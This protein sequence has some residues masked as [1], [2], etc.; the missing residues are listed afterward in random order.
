M[1][2]KLNLLLVLF[3]FFIMEFP[4][5]IL[6]KASFS[7]FELN[8]KKSNPYVPELSWPMYCHDPYHTGRSPYSTANN[9]PD[10]IK[11][12][13]NTGKVSFYGDVAVGA[14]GTI[15]AA[16]N[17]LF[18]VWPNGTLKW[19]FP[20]N[21]W[22][23]GCPAI[24]D[25]GII[26]IGCSMHSP[27]YLYALYPNGQLEW[28]YGV[29]GEEVKS[30][31]VLGADGTIFYGSGHSIRALYPNGT[32]RWDYRTGHLVY[33]SPA[34][35]TDGT[36]YCGSHDTYLYALYPNNGSMKWKYKTGNWIRLSPCIG[37][38]GTIYC[39]SDDEYL[40]ALRPNGT[41]KWKTKVEGGAS[42]TIASDGTIYAGMSTLFAINPGDGSV[43]WTF[44]VGGEIVMSAAVTS[45]E[46]T[47]YFGM[48]LSGYDGY[49]IAVN[50][51]GTEQWRTEIDHCES[52]P[53]I[54]ADGTIYIG[55][56][57][58][59][60]ATHNGLLNAFGPGGPLRAEANGPY[61]GY[62]NQTI[63]FKGT[64]YGGIPPLTYRWD[65]DDGNTS[66]Q[67]NPHHT[68]HTIANFHATFTVTD[69]QGNTSN[70]TASVSV[71]ADFPT[72]TITRPENA[73]YFRDE[74]LFPWV[75]CLA[76]GRLTIQATAFQEPYGIDCVE[77][78]VDDKLIATDNKAPYEW[79]W[80]TP[81]FGYHIVTLTALDTTGHSTS[82]SIEMK[83]FF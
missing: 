65:F 67:Q 25:E 4:L 72:L 24:S 58:E 21:G 74:K 10:H 78:R 41:L 60:D 64:S 45:A 73:V 55:S 31:P 37:D 52:V 51:N 36:V 80:T 20:V 14:D 83:K 77:F 71:N 8:Q 34:I 49:L 22:C 57:D 47:I 33:S 59:D 6:D 40:Y 42:P 63:Q 56:M 35:G 68:Y 44:P 2:R 9:P 5:T 54:G 17:G 13:F 18:A 50:P 3:L 62:Y 76:F 16:A 23:E 70:D 11:W 61:H 30:S 38:D 12:V 53:A 46:G 48:T 27:S 26:Y 75:W 7:N 79:T 15:Y 66:D 1:K 29:G 82:R 81:A 32:L 39:V 43:K 28:R 19:Y 69:A